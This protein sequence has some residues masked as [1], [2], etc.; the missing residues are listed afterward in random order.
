MDSLFDEK[1]GRR[2]ESDGIAATGA[3]SKFNKFS[4]IYDTVASH[5]FI[6]V[7]SM[8]DNL[9][10][11][12]Q[13]FH[14]DQAVGISS[15]NQQGTARVKYG[16]HTL[17][18]QDALYSP[19]SSSGIISAGRLQRLANIFPDYK[20]KMLIRLMNGKPDEPIARLSLYN[21]VY[22]IRPLY[23]AE[24]NNTNNAALGVARIP[25]T[26]SIQRWHQ[27][28][29]HIGQPI[30]KRTKDLSLGL[31]GIDTSELKTCET[32]HLSKAQRFVSREP[33]PM[34]KHPLDEVFI[35]TVGK[36]VPSTDSLQYA[37]I[38]TGAKTRMRWVLTTTTKDQITLT[39]V[40]WVQSMHHQYDR[41]VRT[42]FGDG[43]SEFIKI[44]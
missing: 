16:N 19:K 13:P 30:L 42:I 3:S 29:G 8:F 37:T 15:L 33:R 18:L 40:N 34:P 22:Y 26:E 7:R 17:I 10:K 21:D 9:S 38:I 32:C 25:T 39:L 31:E 28:L 20:N 41:R 35:V 43:G 4:V 27:R 12:H 23:T 24:L 36:L 44:K 14:F 2:K 11:R 5:H 6:P 1:T